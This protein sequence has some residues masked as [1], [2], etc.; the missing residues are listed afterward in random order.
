[1]QNILLRPA[2]T[3]DAPAFRRV[4]E[5]ASEG[6][7]PWVWAQ[8]AGPDGNLDDIVLQRMREKIE[9]SAQGTCLVAEVDGQTAGGVITYDIGDEPEAIEDDTPPL[10]K[11][12]IQLENLAPRTHYVNALAVFPE[13]QGLGIGRKLLRAVAGN[14]LEKGMSLIV[15][16]S[17][18]AALKLY[19]SEWYKEKARLPVVEA[20][21]WQCPG[22]E[23]ILMIRLPE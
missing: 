23:W 18:V 6:L 19:R 20:E 3:N 14:A 11:P 10:F 17:N 1:M 8:S 7:A 12:L 21:G 22:T 16:D 15:E 2:N 4:F 9:K 5:L 13:F